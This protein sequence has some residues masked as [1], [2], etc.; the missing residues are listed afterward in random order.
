MSLNIK[1]CLS[2]ISLAILNSCVS[3]I[4]EVVS[5]QYKEA[6]YTAIPLQAFEEG[7]MEIRYADNDM[8][9]GQIYDTTKDL[10]YFNTIDLYCFDLN[11]KQ[12]EWENYQKFKRIAD[13]MNDAENMYYYEYFGTQENSI[14]TFYRFI[15][16]KNDE[17]LYEEFQSDM[18]IC[19]QFFRY[20]SSFVLLSSNDKNVLTIRVPNE[21]YELEKKYSYDDLSRCIV[22][23]AKIEGDYLYFEVLNKESKSLYR[24]NLTNGKRDL[25]LEH[26][27]DRFTITSSYIVL[28]EKNKELVFDKSGELLKTYEYDTDFRSARWSSKM[29]GDGIIVTDFN[30]NMYY[31]D[32]NDEICYQM[33]AQ[34]DPIIRNIP[35]RF[36]T[37]EDSIIAES[38]NTLYQIKIHL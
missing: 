29:K 18:F 13:Y 19:P 32:L 3:S 27:F 23:T 20:H 36:L 11:T 28:H 12:L 15:D 26:T 14:A 37:T 9:Y 22:A 38:D 1:I 33:S 24:T 35:V 21:S 8:I 7:K 10:I 17:K 31:R 25:V 34:N 6:D 5:L 4:P 16:G 30:N 2:F